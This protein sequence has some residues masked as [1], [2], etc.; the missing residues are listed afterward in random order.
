MAS[1]P[2]LEASAWGVRGELG[3][4][5]CNRASLIFWS[6]LF[7]RRLEA[8]SPVVLA[9]YGTRLWGRA[10]VLVF[11]CFSC[12]AYYCRGVVRLF[13]LFSQF[14][15]FLPFR[16]FET[17]L[18]RCRVCRTV[19]LPRSVRRCYVRTGCKQRPPPVLLVF[20]KKPTAVV[21][22]GW[23]KRAGCSP[24]VGR[25]IARQLSTRYVGRHE[26]SIC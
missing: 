6:G 25:H 17:V 4:G 3:S 20:C 22:G 9:G 14:F 24:D 19:S 10:C 23:L 26:C 15:F 8:G 7:L 12:V 5:V 1:C 21:R 13:W 2:T 18:T 16:R 11:P